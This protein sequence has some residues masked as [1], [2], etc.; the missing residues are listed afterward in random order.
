MGRVGFFKV[1]PWPKGLRNDFFG[2]VKAS[3]G[4]IPCTIL[5]IITYYGLKIV[6]PNIEISS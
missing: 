5:F 3:Q 6:L 4:P 1:D 2:L